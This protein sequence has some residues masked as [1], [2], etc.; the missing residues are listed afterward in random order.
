MA[1][2]AALKKLIFQSYNGMSRPPM[3][4]NI[5]IMPM[6]GLLMAALITGIAGTALLSW[7][8]GVSF[9]VVF[10][11]VL[12]ALQVMCKIDPQYTRRV[13]FGWRRLRRNFKHG[14]PLLLT[15]YNADW[16]KFYGRRFAQVRHSRRDD[17]SA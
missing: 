2:N 12:V 15:P 17:S 1:S 6:V 14:K 5:P 8:W 11:S 16:S 10:L 9:A 7:K 13:R 3:F 4:M